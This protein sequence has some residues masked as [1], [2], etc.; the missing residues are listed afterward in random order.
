[1]NS[2]HFILEEKFQARGGSPKDILKKSWEL[3]IL[4]H[5]NGP[6]QRITANAISPTVKVDDILCLLESEREARRL[7]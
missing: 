5:R 6:F 3:G 4:D 7:R 1:M 2:I